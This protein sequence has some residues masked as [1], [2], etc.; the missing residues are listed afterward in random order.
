MNDK[1]TPV[2][3]D[4]TPSPYNAGRDAGYEYYYHDVEASNPYEEGTEEYDQ[5]QCGFEDG[6]DEAHEL[7]REAQAEHDEYYRF[8]HGED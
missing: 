3:D 6:Q 7:A 1:E 8:C 5:W 2:R 4:H